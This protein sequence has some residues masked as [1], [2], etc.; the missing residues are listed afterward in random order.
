MNTSFLLQT[1]S[2][3]ITCAI[4]F[5]AF[6]GGLWI[7]IKVSNWLEEVTYNQCVG[8]S[9]RLARWVVRSIEQRVACECQ[10]DLLIQVCKAKRGE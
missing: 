4:A 10:K 3:F 5:C 2:E 9:S 7:M 6:G 1:L 8:K